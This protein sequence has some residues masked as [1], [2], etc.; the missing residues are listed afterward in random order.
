MAI[1]WFSFCIFFSQIWIKYTMLNSPKHSRNSLLNRLHRYVLMYMYTHTCTWTW[2]SPFLSLSL[3]LSLPHISPLFLF[4]P[5]STSSWQ[6][7]Q[8][9]RSSSAYLTVR[10]SLLTWRRSLSWVT[11]PSLVVPRT[12]PWTGR[13]FEGG[14]GLEGR[15]EWACPLR[16]DCSCTSGK[17]TPSL[18]PR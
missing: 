5:P 16:R 17:E 12:L 14:W 7:F 11:S 2:H 6:S 1:G 15:W 3:S 8:S 10:Y 4:P 18:L 9:A 13:S